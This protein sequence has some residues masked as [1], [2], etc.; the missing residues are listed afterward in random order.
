V[1]VGGVFSP[2]G[3]QSSPGHLASAIFRTEVDAEYL[4][5]RKT[6]RQ[7]G[8]N[9]NLV[10]RRH[11]RWLE[12]LKFLGERGEVLRIDRTD[13]DRGATLQSGRIELDR[14]FY[15]G[16]PVTKTTI[17]AVRVHRLVLRRRGKQHLHR[18]THRKIRVAVRP[19]ALRPAWRVPHRS[20]MRRVSAVAASGDVSMRRL[21]VGMIM[22]IV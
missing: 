8:Q 2:A 16:R 11:R 12:R 15:A 10:P 5:S 19:R 1:A 7:K 22:N 20:S 21:L 18:W 3:R 6:R 17:L 14:P 4:Q 13:R 9:L